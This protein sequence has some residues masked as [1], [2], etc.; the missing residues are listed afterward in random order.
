M[1]KI[2]LA[3]VLSAAF[4]AVQPAFA[5]DLDI[6]P[7]VVLGGG[8]DTNN[9]TLTAN[10]QVQ[11]NGTFEGIFN[12]V[13]HDLSVNTLTGNM[14]FNGAISGNAS[15]SLPNLTI[16][17]GNH[18]V[19]LNAANSFTGD[20]ILQSGTLKLGNASALGSGS[21]EF[22][23]TTTL[24]A[25]TLD[26]NGLA[27]ATE[28]ANIG[29]IGASTF[30]NSSAT[31]ASWG[32]G[33][34]ISGFPTNLTFSTTAGD[35]GVSGAISGGGVIKTGSGILSVSGN[36]SGL[37]AAWDLVGGTLKFGN[38]HAAGM[39]VLVNGN[40]T[41]IDL[42]GQNMAA[43]TIE[44]GAQSV[45]ISNSA[46]SAATWSGN[47]T[48]HSGTLLT[49]NA[50]AGNLTVGGPI[51]QSSGTTSMLVDGSWVTQLTSA[52]NEFTGNVLINENA[53]LELSAGAL[54][55]FVIGAN[56]ISN[57]IGGAGSFNNS[58][59]FLINL[60]GAGTTIG[61]SWV[62]IDTDSLGG[63]STTGSF[64]ITGFTQVSASKWQRNNFGTLYEFTAFGGSDAGKLMVI[65][66]PSTAFLA[67][68]GGL[69]FIV[70]RRRG[71]LS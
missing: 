17:A 34:T 67:A 45:T 10:G 39:G 29:G 2:H 49:F 28:A 5:A 59:T 60:S 15:S 24:G 35:I 32:G 3:A 8:T 44:A 41:T 22:R 51:K 47:I 57:Q 70:A 4:L 7:T 12:A 38:S 62:L 21:G 50:A 43:A 30:T 58:G 26:L 33:I 6:P 66:E 61:D 53:T 65:P 68:M 31:A 55:N 25:A 16:T 71:K 42:N 14:I 19:E 37:T 40:G 11:G 36:N 69:A 52:T 13:N 18:T 1:K 9:Y 48:T 64:S 56:G 54:M 20:L 27:I 23:T 63:Y 46:G